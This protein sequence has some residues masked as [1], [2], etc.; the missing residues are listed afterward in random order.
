MP[1]LILCSAK[2]EPVKDLKGNLANFDSKQD[3][4]DY[5]ESQCSMDMSSAFIEQV[6]SSSSKNCHYLKILDKGSR[7][8]VPKIRKNFFPLRLMNIL[9][10]N[11]FNAYICW[12]EDGRSFIIKDFS[13]FSNQV[14]CKTFYKNDNA[15]S[16]I[17]KMHRWGFKRTI[18]GHGRHQFYHHLF[19]RDAPGLCKGMMC[20]S[21]QARM[22][23]LTS[24]DCKIT[25]QSF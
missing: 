16:F 22:R 4:L 1:R 25:R 19:V 23:R 15:S 2:N 10:N 18:R 6:S 12:S 9:N 8:E 24:L 7:K 20:M 14:L 11:Y 17:R 5:G 13:V 3:P 21:K